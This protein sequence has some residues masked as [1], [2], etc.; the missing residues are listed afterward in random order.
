MRTIASP[1]KQATA[2]F[3]AAL[4]LLPGCL[5]ASDE[6]PVAEQESELSNRST[7]SL[8]KLELVAAHGSAAL[9]TEGDIIFGK[10]LWLGGVGVSPVRVD[11]GNSPGA[12][13]FPFARLETVKLIA[14]A[15]KWVALL[16]GGTDTRGQ[17]L[18]ALIATLDLSARTPRWEGLCAASSASG[19][20]EV[21]EARETGTF[22]CSS[23]RPGSGYSV[24]LRTSTGTQRTLAGAL[25]LPKLSASGHLLAYKVA[26]LGP[27]DARRLRVYDVTSQRE[28][29]YWG[30]NAQFG[31]VGDRLFAANGNRLLET[32]L[33]GQRDVLAAQDPAVRATWWLPRPDGKLL[34]WQIGGWDTVVSFAVLDTVSGQA[35]PVA[36]PPE[37][38]APQPSSPLVARDGSFFISF[39]ESAALPGGEQEGSAYL[40]VIGQDG[41]LKTRLLVPRLRIGE[42]DLQ[43]R[44]T[45]FEQRCQIE[46]RFVRCTEDERAVRVQTFGVDAPTDA[47]I[48]AR[49]LFDTAVEGRVCGTQGATYGCAGSN[50][51]LTERR[52]QG[53]ADFLTYLPKAGVFSQRVAAGESLWYFD[54]S[55]RARQR[56]SVQTCPSGTYRPA[57]TYVLQTATHVFANDCGGI[58]AYRP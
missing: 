32:S 55:A 40:H 33:V 50:G 45:S 3:V 15:G 17:V 42:R 19:A 53:S 37:A 21:V 14:Q 12:V 11:A 44:P 5:G 24:R 57:Q 25:D 51:D 36:L 34:L 43:G 7:V 49:V 28:A 26:G 10:M 54:P 1:S 27:G 38:F 48:A 30:G 41:A 18:P 20:A 29:H 46:G 52:G 9:Y 31:F 8:G 16:L 23:P 6:E 4:S 58:Y 35:S 39:R 13:S 56:L 47:P 22:L 2:L